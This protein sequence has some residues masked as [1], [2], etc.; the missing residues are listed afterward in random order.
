MPID[1][2][3]AS[4]LI[5]DDDPASLMAMQEVLQSLGARLVPAQ[6]GEEAL[7]KVLE[8]D[9]AAILLDVHMPSTTK[10]RV[11]NTRHVSAKVI[12]RAAPY[13]IA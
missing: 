11:K 12:A 13:S 4:V 10:P 1:S 6:S 3:A 8:D 2:A 7:R 5:V 9:F